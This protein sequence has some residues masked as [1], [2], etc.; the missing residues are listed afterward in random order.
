MDIDAHNAQINELNDAKI[1]QI[2]AQSKLF[3]GIIKKGDPLYK[4]IINVILFALLFPCMIIFELAIGIKNLSIYIWKSLISFIDFTVIAYGKTKQYIIVNY[5]FVQNWIYIKCSLLIAKLWDCLNTSLEFLTQK[6]QQV[7]LLIIYFFIAF[8]I[9]YVIIIDQWIKLKSIAL[10]TFCDYW[11]KKISNYIK[12]QVLTLTRVIKKI[13]KF[14]IFKIKCFILIIFKAI[15]RLTI[16]LKEKIIQFLSYVQQILQKISKFFNEYVFIPLKNKIVNLSYYLFIQFCHYMIKIYHGS[17]YYGCLILNYLERKFL[18]FL[19]WI[20]VQIKLLIRC[21]KYL[22]NKLIDFF[23]L[24][25]DF[26]LGKYKQLKQNVISPVSLKLKEVSK[27][28]KNLIID[29]TLKCIDLIKLALIYL[30]DE[31]IIKLKVKLQN[32]YKNGSKVSFKVFKLL[33]K[34]GKMLSLK[35]KQIYNKM[36]ENSAKRYQ[37]FVLKMNRLQEKMKRIAQIIL[38]NIKIAF[39]YIKKLLKLGGQLINRF[40][41]LLFKSMKNFIKWIIELQCKIIVKFI[42]AFRILNPIIWLI[43]KIF[44]IFFNI[45]S[46]PYIQLNKIINLGIDFIMYVIPNKLYNGIVYIIEKLIQLFI[47]IERF[48]NIVIKQSKKIITIINSKIIQPIVRTSIYLY[49]IM[50]KVVL[51]IVQSL[52]NFKDMIKYDYVLPAWASIRLFAVKIRDSYLKI[53]QKVILIINYGIYKLKLAYL[54]LRESIL[55]V[56]TKI[57]NFIKL[58]IK[59]IKAQI[60]LLWQ[61]IKYVYGIMIGPLIQFKNYIIQAFLSFKQIISNYIVILRDI[62][63]GQC[64]IVKQAT[65][66]ILNKMKE[67]LNK[68]KQSMIDQLNA[69]KIILNNIYDSLKLSLI[70]IKNQINQQMDSIKQSL[71]QQKNAIAEQFRIIRQNIRMQGVQVKESIIN[72]RNNIIQT[73]KIMF[74]RG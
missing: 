16:Y 66:A 33:Q 45:I 20:H 30:R 11:Y 57:T 38:Q 34:R 36:R 24:L 9:K 63:V 53:K 73:I 52:I 40:V 13:F 39:N 72:I 12:I 4:N 70:S 25:I 51:I 17:N 23:L 31:V 8:V 7:K 68:I 10:F 1:Q 6:Y 5:Y 74:K 61:Q 46:Y 15:K 59:F 32:I 22:K 64:I 58:L 50:K 44:E 28:I 19:D 27:K 2:K 49:S 67:L 69:I 48:I 65:L 29:I 41:K 35:A 55:F 71:I 37:K 14:I 18:Q 42:I 54:F 62:I 60:Q 56:K 26:L 3:G 21:M 47:K 43:E